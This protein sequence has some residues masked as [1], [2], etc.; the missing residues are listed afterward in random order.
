[1]VIDLNLLI[2]H[3]NIWV[4]CWT[5][6]LNFLFHTCLGLPGQILLSYFVLFFIECPKTNMFSPKSMKDILMSVTCTV[7]SE[8]GPCK[9]WDTSLCYLPTV[10]CPRPS[11]PWKSW[12]TKGHPKTVPILFTHSVLCPSPSG[13]YKSWDI[14]RQSLY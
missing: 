10:Q 4:C 13:P 5:H 12:D 1:M 14:P 2:A 7:P 9:T 8:I 3:K 6:V 11:G